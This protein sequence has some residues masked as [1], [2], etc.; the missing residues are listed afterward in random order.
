MEYDLSLRDALFPAP[1]IPGHLQYLPSDV[2]TKLGDL[3]S[4]LTDVETLIGAAAFQLYS[5]TGSRRAETFSDRDFGLELAS[6]ARFYASFKVSVCLS[7]IDLFK[8]SALSQVWLKQ[9]LLLPKN[10]PS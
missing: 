2:W 10:F 8:M 6:L 1:E 3:K 5:A 7:S 4:T 9:A